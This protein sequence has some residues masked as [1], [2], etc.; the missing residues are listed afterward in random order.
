MYMCADILGSIFP[1][2]IICFTNFF[3]VFKY[4]IPEIVTYFKKSSHANHEFRSMQKQLQLPELKLI[5][6]VITRWNSTLAM[7]SRFHKNKGAIVSALARLKAELPDTSAVHNLA[8][9]NS[10]EWELLSTLETIF[11]VFEQVTSEISGQRYVTASLILVYIKLLNDKITKLSNDPTYYSEPI[12]NVIN[13]LKQEFLERFK[14]YENSMTLATSTILDPRIKK[15]GFSN[16]KKYDQA[17]KTLKS[18]IARIVQNTSTNPDRVKETTTHQQANLNEPNPDDIWYQFDAEAKALTGSQ[19]PV[20]TAE[21]EVEKYLNEPLIPRQS[22]PLKYW[23]ERRY[24][25]PNL[26][27][28][29]K[30]KLCVLAT[31]VPSERIFSKTGNILSAKRSR[32]RSSKVSKMIFVK[33][34]LH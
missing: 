10:T 16:V 21:I 19:Q 1:K 23:S 7:I 14:N 20:T 26:F 6:D 25:Y 28:Y 5:Q 13:I 2:I 31:S 24:I 12:Q 4:L 18:N 9:L 8:I 17:V 32:L 3:L 15:L 30:S 11:Q 33:E 34:N 27:N 22:D 29:M